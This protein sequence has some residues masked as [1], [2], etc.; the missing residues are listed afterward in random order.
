VDLEA[1]ARTSG[2]WLR[3]TGPQCDIVISS[4]VRLARNVQGH[5][6]LTRA[7]PPERQALEA[8]LRGAVT[9]TLAPEGGVYV[10]LQAASDLDQHLLMER[11]LISRALVQAEGP[12]G[13][14]FGATE[15]TAIMVNE[16]DHLR[17]QVMRSGLALDDGWDAA[18]ALDDRLGDR[19]PYAFSPA[20]GYLTACPS[21]VGTGVRV[22]VMLHLPGL[23]WTKQ[24][25]KVFESIHKMGLAVRGL[26]GEGT[27]ASGDFFQ[28]SNQRTLG[29]SETDIVMSLGAVVPRVISYERR[30]RQA[31]LQQGRRDL[32][33]RVSRAL[34]MLRTAKTIS[35]EETL[36]YLSAVRVGVNLGLI[37]DVP[38]DRI[39]ELFILTQPAHLQ[40]MNRQ[41]LEREDRNALRADFIRT[42]LNGG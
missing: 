35:S 13:V 7:A 23:V 30:A 26:Y 31:L 10:A 41:V 5:P 40:K 2:E 29:Q 27:Q 33:D 42:R 17:L 34:G 19:V 9:E 24:I 25:N 38:I 20:L 28:V 1:L 6:F 37:Q 11:H 36:L 8:L 18:D 3:G 16:E 14:G 4:R 32:D 39:N 22:S 21:N 12:R 15:A